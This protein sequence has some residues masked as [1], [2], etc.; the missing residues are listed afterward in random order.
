MISMKTSPRSPRPSATRR[1]A[2]PAPDRR[3][4]RG[5]LP[6][7]PERQGQGGAREGSRGEGE[8]GLLQG[9]RRR[10]PGP[11]RG[12]ARWSPSRTEKVLYQGVTADGRAGDRRRASAASRWRGSR[13]TSTRRSSRGSRRSCSRTRGRIDP[14]RIE[15]YIAADGYLALVDGAH[16]DDARRGHRAG[17]AQRACAAAAARASRP[18]EVGHRRQG[19]RRAE[20]RHLQ[21][22]R[23]R[24]G[25][26]HGPQRA[27]ERPAPRPRRHG[28][29]RLRGRRAARA[30]STSAPSIRWRSS[31]SKTAHRAGRASSGCSA[32]SICGTTFNFHVDIRLGA[33]AFV[34]GEETALIASIE[35]KRGTPRPAPAVPGRIGPL[36]HARRSS[37]T[38]RR[39]ANIAADHPQRRASGSR[40]SA[41]RRA[42]ARR[43]SRSPARSPTPA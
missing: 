1:T 19:R 11:L 18:A 29:R 2:S 35:G 5:E 42:R 25:R 12:R 6:V 4:R 30:S 43:S 22:R 31:G 32:T 27:R 17:H 37:T 38:S 20:V 23:G 41:R 28:D 40:R 26:V 7:P 9:Q 33:G 14:E 13:A 10:L 36:G 21:R 39:F 34:C 3:L 24:P 16:R 8:E 15:D